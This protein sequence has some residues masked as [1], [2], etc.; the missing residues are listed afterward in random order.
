MA[1]QWRLTRHAEAA[2]VDI[3]LWTLE[4]FGPRQAEAY[5]EDL[6]ERCEALA[7]GTA[8][9]QSC[10]LLMGQLM[11]QDLRFTRAGQ[12]LVVYVESDDAIT[13]L[14]F[15]HSR[16]DLPANLRHLA[17]KAEQSRN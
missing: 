5:E 15:L 8:P 17:A 10:G 7:S 1:K 6:I 12:H 9:N 14:D 11:E 13:I 3:A 2:L 16:S 4:T